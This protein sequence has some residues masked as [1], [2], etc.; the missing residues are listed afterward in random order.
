MLFSQLF[1][2]K[3]VRKIH[4]T[5]DTSYHIPIGFTFISFLKWWNLVFFGCL[6][7]FIVYFSSKESITRVYKNHINKMIS[8]P[9]TIP[10]KKPIGV[11]VISLASLASAGL[12]FIL[13][14][15]M[16]GGIEIYINTPGIIAFGIYEIIS[17]IIS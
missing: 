16:L 1:D 9:P 7:F 15:L 17:L 6:I 10:S 14:L 13:I 2:E 3:F 4:I 11:I 5:F 12:R 8:L